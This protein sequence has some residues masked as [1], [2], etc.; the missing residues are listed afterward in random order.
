MPLFD[1]QGLRCPA[2]G[3]GTGGHGADGSL[4][5]AVARIA[6]PE[7]AVRRRVDAHRQRY[8]PQFAPLDGRAK[9]TPHRLTGGSVQQGLSVAGDV[10]DSNQF[11]RATDKRY[12]LGVEKLTDG[13]TSQSRTTSR[14]R[15]TP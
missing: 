15:P 7:P 5:H 4:A 14:Q 6:P 13:P 8:V 1:R 11:G 10:R 12:S 3:R 9:Q 2:F